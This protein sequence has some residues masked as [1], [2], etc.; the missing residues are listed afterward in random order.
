MASCSLLFCCNRIHV[1]SQTTENKTAISS[2]VPID[3]TKKKY[4]GNHI[5]NFCNC[6][7]IGSVCWRWFATIF[8]GIRWE[9]EKDE[10]SNPSRW[11]NNIGE[12]RVETACVGLLRLLFEWQAPI[13]KTLL[14]NHHVRA[15]LK[16]HGWFFSQEK[17]T[18]KT[19]QKVY[20]STYPVVFHQK[21]NVIK[22]YTSANTRKGVSCR[23]FWKVI[24]HLFVET[25]AMPTSYGRFDTFDFDLKTMQIDD[26]KVSVSSK[27]A[28]RFVGGIRPEGFSSKNF[29][30]RWSFTAALNIWMTFWKSETVRDY[31]KQSVNKL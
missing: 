7:R 19:R 5:Q 15:P 17:P 20:H 21:S 26:P 27:T 4:N 1:W 16:S 10:L 2:I 6:I 9:I 13:L 3:A 11:W 18:K 23:A 8:D 29:A 24:I 28:Q 12:W 31:F 22:F 14:S 25:K 30:S